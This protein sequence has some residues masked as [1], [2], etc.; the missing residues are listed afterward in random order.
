MIAQGR[1]PESAAT[2]ALGVKGPIGNRL[3]QMKVLPQFRPE[4]AMKRFVFGVLA[5]GTLMSLYVLH[6]IVGVAALVT[7]F[8][9]TFS[10]RRSFRRGVGVHEP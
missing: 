2:P 1:I 4:A 5:V 10:S 8:T 7:A 6:P 9:Y 3:A